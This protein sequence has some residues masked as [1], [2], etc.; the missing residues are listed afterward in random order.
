MRNRF[1][2]AFAITILLALPFNIREGLG[3]RDWYVTNM[4]AFEQDLAEG[5]SWQELADR[6][7]QFQGWKRD[8]L[9]E[10]MRM[11]H[12]AK[13]EPFGRGAPR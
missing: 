12:E 5:L 1:A 11:L 2:I 10:W 9:V 8:Y 13:I 3:E 6:Q 4:R 7:R